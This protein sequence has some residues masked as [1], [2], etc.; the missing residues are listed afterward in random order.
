MGKRRSHFIKIQNPE[1]KELENLS[2]AIYEG[3][4]YAHNHLA[5]NRPALITGEELGS[6]KESLNES[7]EQK[8][9]E[10]DVPPVKKRNTVLGSAIKGKFSQS[11]Q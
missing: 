3:V 4:K 8:I 11:I 1:T 7:Q 6:I 2:K 5:M 10:E 9:T